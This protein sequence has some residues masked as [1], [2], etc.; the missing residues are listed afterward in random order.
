MALDGKAMDPAAGSWTL[1]PVFSGSSFQFGY[2]VRGPAWCRGTAG[3][4]LQGEL[5]GPPWRVSEA[6]RA[7]SLSQRNAPS[8]PAALPRQMKPNAFLDMGITIGKHNAADQLAGNE[9]LLVA[10]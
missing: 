7:T 8:P 6:T 5:E 3:G 2:L 4:T 1:D 9:Q 10:A